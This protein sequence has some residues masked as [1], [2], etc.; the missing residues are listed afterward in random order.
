ML[1]IFMALITDYLDGYIARSQNLVTK[2]GIILDPIADRF[3]VLIASLALLVEAKLSLIALCAI[4]SRDI[5]LF[6]FWLYM[7][8]RGGW[9]SYRCQATLWGKITTVVQL[10]LLMALTL[11]VV[12]PPAFFIVMIILGFFTF[13]E[14]FYRLDSTLI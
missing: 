7:K 10:I 9:K 4:F 1:V 13:I 12:F 6:I 3:F 14:L 11:N 2:V 8:Y 5:F